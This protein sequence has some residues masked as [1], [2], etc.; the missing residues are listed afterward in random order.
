MSKRLRGV[1]SK[2]S[3]PQPDA[4]FL[5]LGNAA[6]VNIAGWMELR[7]SGYSR[8]APA[9][10]SQTRRSFLPELGYPQALGHLNFAGRSRRAF[11]LEKHAD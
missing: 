4:I 3:A 11:L 5:R 6:Q 1:F 2:C 9:M 8:E 7:P 10:S